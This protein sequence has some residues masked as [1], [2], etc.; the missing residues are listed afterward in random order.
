MREVARVVGVSK[1]TFSKVLSG[2]GA[3]LRISPATQSQVRAVANQLG[4]VPGPLVRYRPAEVADSLQPS[5]T[6]PMPPLPVSIPVETEPAPVVEAE[7]PPPAVEPV[8]LATPPSEPELPLVEPSPVSLVVET[9]ASPQDPVTV[10]EAAEP[11]A[12]P[13]AVEPVFPA[14]PHP[15][16]EPPPMEAAAPAQDPATEQSESSQGQAR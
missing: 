9:E 15:E 3:A 12:P 10:V 4:Y 2:K 5:I 16:A 13:P 14:V 1:A 8:F 11:V 7:T 6:S